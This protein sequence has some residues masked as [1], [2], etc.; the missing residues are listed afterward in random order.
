MM[1]LSEHD[2]LQHTHRHR[3]HYYLPIASFSEKIE[4]GKVGVT[5]G[6]RV[7]GLLYMLPDYLKRSRSF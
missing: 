2:M 5:W 1:V 3:F 7:F 4:I 6:I